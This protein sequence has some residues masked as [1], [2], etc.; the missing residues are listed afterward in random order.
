MKVIVL[1]PDRDQIGPH[2][3]ST[4]MVKRATYK[5]WRGIGPTVIRSDLEK[6]FFTTAWNR[7]IQGSRN[8]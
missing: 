5:R 8:L 3:A 7:F 6:D 4:A 2:G 1:L